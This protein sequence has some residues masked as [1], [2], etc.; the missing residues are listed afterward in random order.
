MAW[1]RNRIPATTHLVAY[2]HRMGVG[3]VGRGALAG[4]EDAGLYRRTGGRRAS[5][6]E[7]ARSVAR[8]V[9][10]FDQRGCVSPHLIFVEEGGET[11]PG[12]WAR[13]LSLALQGLEEELPSGPLSAEDGVVLQQL[14]GKAELE[15]SLGRGRVFHGGAAAPWTVLFQPGGK[16]E[17]SCL[18]RMVRVIPVE[19][20][21]GILPSLKPWAPHLQT[22]GVAGLGEQRTEVLEGLARL[23]VSRIVD[24]A[25]VPWPTPW[26]HHDGSGPLRALVR[27]TDVEES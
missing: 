24:M 27:W 22:V 23:G 2:R 10:I 18:N 26:W 7:T 11:E 6:A 25:R 4:G 5:A 15:E 1:V 20:V 19:Q 14:R 3:V 21:K 12:E 8:A 16:T 13:Q 9:A 17:P